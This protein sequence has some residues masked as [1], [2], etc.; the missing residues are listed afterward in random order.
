MESSRSLRN[1][2]IGKT[3]TSR[4][5]CMGIPLNGSFELTSRCN[6]SCRMCYVHNMQ[7]SAEL[8]K[9]ELTAAQWLEIAE[10]AKR[11]GTLFLLLTGGEAML[12]EDFAE[13]Y[14]KL[15]VMGFRIVVNSNGSMLTDEILDCFRKYPPGR[16]NVSVRP[17]GICAAWRREPAWRRMSES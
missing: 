7:N 11:C 3:L 5:N 2:P 6:F 15:S 4:A 1:F 14:C 10:D 8:K 16:V 12:R 17:T 9:R 13:I